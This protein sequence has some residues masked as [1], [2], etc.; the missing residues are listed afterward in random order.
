MKAQRGT[1][2]LKLLHLS[3]FTEFRPSSETVSQALLA[4]LSDFAQCCSISTQRG[5]WG[6]RE[7][8][9]ICQALLAPLRFCSQSTTIKAERETLLC[10]A[11]FASLTFCWEQHQQAHRERE[12]ETHTHRLP[13]SSLSLKFCSECSTIKAPADTEFVVLLQALLAALM[14]LTPNRFAHSSP[15]STQN[16]SAFETDPLRAIAATDWHQ[17]RHRFQPRNHR[18][19]ASPAGMHQP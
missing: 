16:S 4:P 7:S 6:E 13:S 8:D 15:T 11:L 19:A 10:Q 12:R 1:V 14:V 3:D 2:F 17:N 18:N 5:T 9:T